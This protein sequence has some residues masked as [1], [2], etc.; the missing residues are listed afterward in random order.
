MK[1][2]YLDNAATT[3]LDE[4]VFE[5]MKPYF[6]E[7]F[8]NPESQHSFGKQAEFAVIK[9]REQV[10]SAL[11]VLDNEIYFTC[12]A[13]EANNWALRGAVFSSQKPKKRIIISAIEHSSVLNCG[14]DLVEQGVEVI[15]VLP[16]K[17]GIISPKSVTEV[18]DENTI[19]VSIMLANNEVGSIQPIKEICQAVK[20][21]NKDI[22]F[23]TDAVQAIGTLDVNARDLGVDM[24]SLSAHKFYGPKGIGALYIKN[25]VKIGRLIA[26]GNQERGKRGGTSN[27]PAIIGLGE[28][29]TKAVKDRQKNSDRVRALRDYFIEQV[30]K[31]IPYVKLNGH[32]TQRLDGNVNFTFDY[33][34]SQ[35]LINMLD[36][37][38][39]A[40][41]VGSACT[42]GS[43]KPSYV[44][45]AMGVP[46]EL[47]NS[48][49]RFT[50][51]K[52][53]TKEEI[54]YTVSTLKECVEELR[55]ISPLFVNI[56]TEQHLV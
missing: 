13:A 36:M 24:L 39:V 5:A 52:Y 35:S 49:V 32:R 31:N 2:I 34:S 38:G 47:A 29:I 4:S 9:A 11:G 12:G 20:D 33:V 28:A 18:L 56:K 17:D 8:G 45:M 25:G 22:L 42:A 14:E 46:K 43:F 53:N 1:K 3:P 50:I 44:L 40:A 41:S 23:H 7:I 37:K 27:V 55:K 16:D 6:C 10:A 30:E 54:D 19:L 21:Y 26:G 15:Q 51:G 48:S